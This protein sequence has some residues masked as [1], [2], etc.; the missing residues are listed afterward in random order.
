[1]NQLL[2]EQLKNNIEIIYLGVFVTSVK[3]PWPKPL[4][5]DKTTLFKVNESFR[6]GIHNAGGSNFMTGLKH[7]GNMG[8]F[9][10]L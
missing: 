5:F 10:A 1:M 2:N 8:I 3:C 4:K 6:S 9:K 7:V